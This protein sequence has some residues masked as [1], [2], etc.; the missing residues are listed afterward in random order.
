MELKQLLL[1]EWDWFTTAWGKAARLDP[2]LCKGCWSCYDVCPVGCFRPDSHARIVRMVRQDACVACAACVLQC[3]EG[4][5]QMTG[6]RK[7][8]P[9]E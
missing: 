9:G 6:K 1:E 2:T 4:A 7:R 5:L 8:A 3:P